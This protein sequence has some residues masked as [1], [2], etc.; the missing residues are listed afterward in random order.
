MAKYADYKAKQDQVTQELQAV[1]Q[2]SK[3]YEIPDSVKTRFAG[4]SPEE[5]MESFAELQRMNSTQ[6]QELGE[7]RKTTTTLLELQSQPK[8]QEPPTPEQ[9][10]KGITVDDLY[11]DP[12]AAI[13]TVVKRSTKETSERVEALE[14]ELAS[15]RANGVVVALEKKYPGWTAEAKK[16][17]F[18]EWVKQSPVRLKLARAADSYDLDSANDLLELWY[19]RKGVVTQVQDQANR[20]QQFRN[21]SLESSSPVD[22]EHVPTFSRHELER[23]KIAAKMGNRDA[24][25]YLK[26]HGAAIYQAYQEGRITD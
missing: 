8:T 24:E 16:P 2:P 21:A 14:K 4:K 17:E 6:A 10:E 20:E 11:E 5:I 13:G 22:I 23:K 19:E 25:A 15:Y 26:A 3:T 12:T 9:P 18:L 1:T 7:L